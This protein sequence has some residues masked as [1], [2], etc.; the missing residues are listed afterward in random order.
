MW[1][2]SILVN[3]LTA[4][5]DAPGT[6]VAFTLSKCNGL[7]VGAAGIPHVEVPAP[8]G[9]VDA[10]AVT[11]LVFG[12]LVDGL[13]AAVLVS[14]ALVLEVV[15]K[16]LPVDF[17]GGIPRALFPLC[18]VSRPRPSNRMTT[19]GPECACIVLCNLALYAS[20]IALLL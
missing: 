6:T 20:L 5:L 2:H 4:A 11:V 9:G 10:V 18:T 1:H 14:L 3:R 13:E 7:D 17:V 8:W 15:V 16:N 12:I 19:F